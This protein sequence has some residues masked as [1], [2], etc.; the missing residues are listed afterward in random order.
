MGV[1][2]IANVPIIFACIVT[3][4]QS[5]SGRENWH[6]YNTN[7]RMAIANKENQETQTCQHNN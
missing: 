2:E 6:L 7:S 4:Q 5:I 3:I 1:V